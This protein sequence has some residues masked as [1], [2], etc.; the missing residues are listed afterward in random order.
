VERQLV[1]DGPR[2]AWAVCVSVAAAATS[3]AKPKASPRRGRIDYK[4]VLPPEQFERF[5]ALR[6][7][8]KRLSTKE[9]VPPYAVFNNA[10]L[11][12]MVTGDVRT[13]AALARIPGVG[14]ARVKKYGATFLKHLNQP[15]AVGE[16]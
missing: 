9:G 15:D 16:E 7:L 2:S 10:Q 5:A 14:P 12:A 1:Q 13:R 8:R 11:A 3:A 4:A 6:S